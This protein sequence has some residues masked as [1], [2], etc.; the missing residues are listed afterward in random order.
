[1]NEMSY[2]ALTDRRSGICVLSS[3]PTATMPMTTKSQVGSLR[4]LRG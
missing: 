3:S 4:I 1:M 2:R